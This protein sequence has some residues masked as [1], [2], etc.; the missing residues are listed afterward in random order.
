V[1]PKPNHNAIKIF[2]FVRC[3]LVAT[4]G[5]SVRIRIFHVSARLTHTLR[6]LLW[7][8]VHHL[9]THASAVRNRSVYE[10]SMVS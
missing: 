5:L 4:V 8:V 6:Q 9:I 10:H 2:G 1:T 7:E 3:R